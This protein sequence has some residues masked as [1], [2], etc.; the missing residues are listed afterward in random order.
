MSH[1]TRIKTQIMERTYLLQALQDLGYQA[2]TDQQAGLPVRAVGGGAQRVEVKV[3]LGRLGREVGFRKAAGE[4][5]AQPAYE[6]VADWWGLP[7]KTRQEFTE[8]V[9][10][11]YA[12]HAALGQL[13]AQG[14]SLVADETQTDG[15]IH[16]T[17]R[18]VQ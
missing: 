18:R 14:F 17:L 6:I 13:Q 12:Y 5:Q 11:R 16:L 2:E 3:H 9:S 4:G 10:Q 15:Q 1:F 7:G 8:Q